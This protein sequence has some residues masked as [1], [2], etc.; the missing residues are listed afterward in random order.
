MPNRCNCCNAASTV[1]ADNPV[2][3]AISAVVVAPARTDC[4]T[5]DNG[6]IRTTPSTH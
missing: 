1:D 3:R 4:S 5:A 6:R 2:R